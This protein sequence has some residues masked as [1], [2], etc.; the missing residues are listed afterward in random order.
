MHPVQHNLVAVQVEQ[1]GGIADLIPHFSQV[2]DSMGVQRFIES[3]VQEALFHGHGAAEAPVTGGHVFDH[4]EFDIV[5]RGELVLMLGEQEQ[6]LRLGFAIQDD[7]FGEE[8][9]AHGIDGGA[10]FTGR[11]LRAAGAGAVAFGCI[12]SSLRAHERM[13]LPFWWG[14][15]IG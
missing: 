12:D 13:R 3:F 7:A 14:S 1:F 15:H 2:G 5:A 8:T 11:G 4:A 9:V 10:A 6:K